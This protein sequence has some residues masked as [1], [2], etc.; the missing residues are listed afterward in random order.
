ME[1]LPEYLQ[2][3]IYEYQG[4]WK[5]YFREKVIVEIRKNNFYYYLQKNRNKS[6]KRRTG[7][8]LNVFPEENIELFQKYFPNSMFI[9]DKNE[10]IVLM[11]TQQECLQVLRSSYLTT[12]NMNG[13][14]INSL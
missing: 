1:Q 13:W 8:F 6:Q 2:N 5:N 7:Q 3:L 9:Y 12:C 10:A 14:V 11:E 4:Y